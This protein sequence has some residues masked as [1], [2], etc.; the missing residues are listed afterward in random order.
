MD[1]NVV[2][3]KKPRAKYE[4]VIIAVVMVAAIVIAFG[5]YTKRDSAQKGKLLIS[6]L[7]NIRSSIS[8]YKTLNKTN[9]PNIEALT[10]VNY[11]FDRGSPARPYLEGVTTNDG[12]IVDPFGHTYEYNTSNAWVT[13]STKGYE[14]W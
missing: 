12:K 11:S 10:E 7:S 13:S 3:A 6:E 5:I 8:L 14:N 4:W 1:E 9:P 2:K